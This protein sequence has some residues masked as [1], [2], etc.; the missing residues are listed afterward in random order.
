MYGS[1]D[2]DGTFTS[3]RQMFVGQGFELKR[4]KLDP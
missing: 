2:R 3:V 4:Q 1:D